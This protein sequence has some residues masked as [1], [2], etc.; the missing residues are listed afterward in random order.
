[1]PSY[2]RVMTG[3]AQF[4][5]AMQPWIAP[6]PL[7]PEGI[8]LGFELGT[9]RP[10]FIDFQLLKRQG[11]IDSAV[12]VIAGAKNHGKSALVKTLGARQLALQ[13]GRGTDGLPLKASL[14][15]NDRKNEKGRGEMALLTDHLLGDNV[16]L[17]KIGSINPFDPLMGM[18]E[19]ALVGIA[20]NIAE[21]VCHRRLQEV[22][23]LVIQ[24]GVHHM[25]TKI[26]KLMSPYILELTLRK[27]ES[28][29]THD[30]FSRVDATALKRY[31]KQVKQDLALSQTLNLLVMRPDIYTDEEIREAAVKVSAMFG[32]L[33]RA[34]FGPLFN[35][36]Q[37]L[38]KLLSSPIA[39]FEWTGVTGPAEG[40]MEY[41]MATWQSWAL[42]NYDNRITPSV[43]ISDEEASALKSISHARAV[44]E[45][46][47]KARASQMTDFR[48]LQ[49][50][51]SFTSAGDDGS[52]LRGL[53]EVI[54]RN[55]AVRI[56]GKQEPDAKSL[57]ALHQAG[58][59]DADSM[60]MTTIDPYC[61]AL[62]IRN[63][64]V[65]YFESVLLPPEVDLV[66]TNGANI[67]A[68]DRT[69]VTDLPHIQRRIRALGAV[70]IGA[71]L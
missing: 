45:L 51:T 63:Q 34:D 25:F 26:N 70:Q 61:W 49:H 21:T 71:D 36:E 29:D 31:A 52:E 40:L 35:G 22:E 3:T 50:L 66:E 39:N 58:L 14:R 65:R 17:A 9:R 15:S 5:A 18:D 46:S 69:R 37:S 11:V 59:G 8:L 28:A 10:M 44:D 16:E 60:Y 38:L 13:A 53:G 55:I 4:T 64:P 19:L 23:V 41:L 33:L 30:Y 47:V 2:G 20:I 24:V 27:I 57:E 43:N 48:L 6:P 67:S 1:M 12:V 54:N 68:T 7:L 62:I 32:R 56:V 42:N